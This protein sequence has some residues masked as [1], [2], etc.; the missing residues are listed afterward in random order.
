[1]V[2]HLHPE[3]PGAARHCLADAAHAQD[4]Q[5][6]A[7]DPP[8]QHRGGGPAFP[9]ARLH[10]RQPLGDAAGDGEHQRDGHVGGVLGHHARRVRHQDAALAGSGH[11]DMVDA[12]AVIGD[13]L[14]LVTRLRQQRRVDQVG[15][16]GHDH[17]GAAHRVGQFL[18]GHLG[19]GVAQ[20]DVEQL[21]HPGFDGIRQPSRHDNTQTLHGHVIPSCTSHPGLLMAK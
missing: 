8:A 5:A 2:M 10:Q 1:V 6:P 14:Q 9:L 12:R 18:A 16:A 11:V 21:L 13:Q 17:I 20:G 3:D 19:V 7:A 4:A 15:D